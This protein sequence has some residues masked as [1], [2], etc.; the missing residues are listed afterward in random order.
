M[1]INPKGA[2]KSSF[3]LIDLKKISDVLT[4]KPG[5]VVLDLACG[6]GDYSVYFSEIVGE[7]GIVYALDLWEEGIML[8][9]KRIEKQN[10][11]NIIPLISD[12]ARLIEIDDCSVDM[13]LMATVLHDFEEAGQAEAVLKNVKTILKPNGCLAVLEFKKIDGPPGPPKHIR[14][15]EKEV[16]DLVLGHGFKKGSALDT[17]D[18]TYLLNYRSLC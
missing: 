8:L 9:E 10:I 6:R 4:V 13:C 7:Q 11:S 15:S 12:A 1:E 3:E 16:D 14:L 5:S 17:G 18:Y 2:G